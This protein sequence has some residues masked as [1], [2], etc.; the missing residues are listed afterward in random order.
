[1]SCSFPPCR[2][3]THYSY[4][5][6]IRPDWT[7]N[8]ISWLRKSSRFAQFCFSSQLHQSSVWT[9]D[10]IWKSQNSTP[11]YMVYFINC[12]FPLYLLNFSFI[13]HLSQSS[14]ELFWSQFVRHCRHRFRCRKLFKSSTSSPKPL[15]HNKPNLAQSILG[16]RDF[17]YIYTNG[18]SYFFFQGR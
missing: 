10:P 12:L 8:S 15:G 18:G 2:E 17:M 4:L 7:I 11:M 1:M 3:F 13:D 16:W 6:L 9:L 5:L 14:S